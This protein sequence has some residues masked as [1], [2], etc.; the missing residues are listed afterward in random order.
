M[1]DNPVNRVDPIGTAVPSNPAPSIRRLIPIPPWGFEKSKLTGGGGQPYVT[2]ETAIATF[3]KLWVLYMPNV[4]LKRDANLQCSNI[5]AGTEAVFKDRVGNEYRFRCQG[6]EG[7]YH[8]AGVFT[9]VSGKKATVTDVT[10]PRNPKEVKPGKEVG[11]CKER[12]AANALVIHTDS[13][14]AISKIVLFNLGARNAEAAK[15][16]QKELNAITIGAP[17][18]DAAERRLRAIKR[19]RDL[20]GTIQTFT[21]AYN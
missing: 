10:D 3:N 15:A 4:W 1:V 8:L 12:F 14:G 16:L 5:R 21:V 17:N 6:E 13:D 7:D 19:D 18:A 20:P 11:R 2:L 9:A